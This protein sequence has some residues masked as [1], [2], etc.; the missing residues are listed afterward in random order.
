M[1]VWSNRNRFFHK[2][3]ESKSP[4]VTLGS[5]EDTNLNIRVLWIMKRK[6]NSAHVRQWQKKENV[7]RE[8]PSYRVDKQRKETFKEAVSIE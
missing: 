6:P 7:F 8:L 4:Q 3:E 5:K 1:T 2:V